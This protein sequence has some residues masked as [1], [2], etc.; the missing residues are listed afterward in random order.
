MSPWRKPINY[1]RPVLLIGFRDSCL[2][3]SGSSE[4]RKTGNGFLQLKVTT[5]NGGSGPENALMGLWHDCKPSICVESSFLYADLPF[6]TELTLPQFYE[7]L[8]EMEKAKAALDF[9]S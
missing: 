1:D 5:V 6:V 7:F 8:H 9:L 3:T 2:V 4:F